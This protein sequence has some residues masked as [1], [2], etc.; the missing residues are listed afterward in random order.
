MVITKK[1]RS[2]IEAIR[3]KFIGKKFTNKELRLQILSQFLMYEK[4]R[5]DFTIS[6]F[7]SILSKLV[8]N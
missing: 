2:T 3:E 6:K 7:I 5:Y 1:E 4:E 8:I